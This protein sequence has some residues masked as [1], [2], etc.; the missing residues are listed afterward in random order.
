MYFS[1]RQISESLCIT[2][3][4]RFISMYPLSQFFSERQKIS[5]VTA[6]LKLKS[7]NISSEEKLN[8]QVIQK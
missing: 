6:G 5:M 4:L 8:F 7:F 3:L 2:P 1:E